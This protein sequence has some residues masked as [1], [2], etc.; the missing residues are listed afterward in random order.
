MHFVPISLLS[1]SFTRKVDKLAASV[2]LPFTHTHTHTHKQALASMPQGQQIIPD[3]YL[4][5]GLQRLLQRFDCCSVVE[6]CFAH[7]FDVRAHS[8]RPGNERQARGIGVVENI[9]LTTQNKHVN[10]TTQ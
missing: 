5:S 9:R 10:S 8:L 1:P 2:E 3:T 4:V 6:K 7:H